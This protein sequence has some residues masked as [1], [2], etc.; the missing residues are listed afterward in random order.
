MDNR[1]P[2]RYPTYALIN[3]S[4]PLVKKAK[5]HQAVNHYVTIHHLKTLLSYVQSR[6]VRSYGTGLMRG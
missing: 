6:I 3:I 1:T 5:L 2:T 4:F